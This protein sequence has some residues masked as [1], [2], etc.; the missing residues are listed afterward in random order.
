[1]ATKLKR[2]VSGIAAGSGVLTSALLEDGVAPVAPESSPAGVL[3]EEQDARTAQSPAPTT[4]RN[5]ALMFV[6]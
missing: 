1:M 6:V 2:S 5:R 3:P 4:G